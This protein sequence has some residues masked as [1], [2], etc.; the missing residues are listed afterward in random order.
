LQLLL[1]PGNCTPPAVGA[2]A[3]TW[4]QAFGFTR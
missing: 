2:C 4:I 3:H 1:S